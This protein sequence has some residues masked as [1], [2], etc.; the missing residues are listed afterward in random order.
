M[1][2]GAEH[3][4]DEMTSGETEKEM[5]HLRRQVDELQTTGT[6]LV[7]RNRALEAEIKLRRVAF[8][9]ASEVPDRRADVTEFHGLIGQ[10]CGTSPHVPSDDVVR[11]RLRLVAEEF[12]EFVEACLS[13]DQAQW[14][15]GPAK[16]ALADAIKR[17]EIDVDLPAMA[18]ATIDVDYTIEGSRVAFGIDG[19]P[20]WDAVHTANCRK[21]PGGAAKKAE[22]PEGFEPPPIEALLVEQG[23]SP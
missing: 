15:L 3:W 4:A 23:W 19:A 22:K 21:R 12:F 5:A 18:D 9:S 16:A 11:L 1:R 14:Y 10:E 2:T 13:H 17:C 20:L 8:S 7:M 6:A